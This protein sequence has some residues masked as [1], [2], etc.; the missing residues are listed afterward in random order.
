[1][2]FLIVLTSI[3]FILSL[4]KPVHASEEKPTTLEQALELSDKCMVGDIQPAEVA[5]CLAAMNV[6]YKALQYKQS[7]AEFSELKNSI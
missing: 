2:R 6:K 1:M 7:L 5:L 3:L 4:T